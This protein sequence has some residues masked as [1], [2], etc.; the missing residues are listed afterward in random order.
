ML[1]VDGLAWTEASIYLGMAIGLGVFLSTSATM[2]EGLCFQICSRIRVFL[3]MYQ[4]ALVENFGC[5]QLT[6]AW[7]LQGYVRWLQGGRPK[8]ETVTIT[9]VLADKT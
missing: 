2:I 8:W 4:V 7:R 3:K 6:A 5:R 9:S 1:R